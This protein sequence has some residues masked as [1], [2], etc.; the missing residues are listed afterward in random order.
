MRH[1]GESAAVVADI[2]GAVGTDAALMERIVYDAESAQLLSAGFM[3]YAMPRAA[4]LPDLDITL[5]EDQPTEANGLGVKGTGQAGCIA[6]PQAI[7]AA[8]R[9]AVGAEVTMPATPEKLWRAL[10]R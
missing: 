9:D 6:A 5:R 2:D 10:Q 8:I 7:M 4:D 1:E 3:D